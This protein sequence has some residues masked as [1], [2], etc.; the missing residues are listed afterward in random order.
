MRD[1]RGV[2]RYA[3]VGVVLIAVGVGLALRVNV[4]AGVVAGLVGVGFLIPLGG[5]GRGDRS[6]EWFGDSDTLGD[7]GA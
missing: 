5:D 4:P 7:D 1:E 6:S 2:K 3:L